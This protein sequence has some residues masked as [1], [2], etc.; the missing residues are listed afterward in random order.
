MSVAI[1]L[2]RRPGFGPR[3]DQVTFVADKVPLSQY[4]C[5]PRQYYS[6][7]LHLYPARTQ[8]TGSLKNAMLFCKSEKTGIG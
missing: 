4:F 5:F 8:P 2:P 7:H 1:L 6:T 3:S